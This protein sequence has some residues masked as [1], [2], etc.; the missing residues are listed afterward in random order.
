MKCEK[1]TLIGHTAD[2]AVYWEA[3]FGGADWTEYSYGYT[4][5]GHEP[6]WGEVDVDG[7]EMIQFRV[8]DL[9]TQEV[10]DEYNP[11]GYEWGTEV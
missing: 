9:D 7:G 5:Y 10:V 3:V 11:L 2:A 1:D 6:S 8:I 4:C